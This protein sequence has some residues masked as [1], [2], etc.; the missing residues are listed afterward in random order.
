MKITKNQILKYLN[1]FHETE[2]RFPEYDPVITG[3]STDSREIKG[4]ELYIAIKGE[5]ND[6]NDYIDMVVENGAKLVLTSSETDLKQAIIVKDTVESLGN[7]ARGYIEEFDIA[8]LAVTG[9]SGKTTT[10]DMLYYIVSQA[11]PAIATRGN[12][13]NEIGLP[14][15]AFRLESSHRA[16]IFEMGMSSLGEIEYLCSIVKPHIG[17]ITNIGSCHIEHLKTREN[18]FKAKMEITTY[19]GEDNILIV[20]GDDEYLSTLDPAD[21]PYRIIK[22]GFSEKN[23]IMIS[24]YQIKDEMAVFTLSGLDIDSREFVIPA[25]GRHNA[26]NASLCI[27]AAFLMNIPYEKIAKG[28]LDFKPSQLRM[29]IKRKNGITLINDSYNANP[30]SMKAVISSIRDYVSKRR[31]A[32]LAD[33]LELGDISDISH[34]EVIKEA[35]MEFDIVIVIGENMKKASEFV[36]SSSGVQNLLVFDDN[37]MAI[38]KIKSIIK[39]GDIVLIKGSRGMKL[40]HVAQEL[41]MTI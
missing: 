40:D 3:V 16:A 37:D 17:I 11:M 20:N 33:M 9:S 34:R 30:E 28:L 18:I 15:T 19:F 1:E 24:N 41:Q 5:N 7:I 13:N 2:D 35:L 36:I 38:N 39:Y 25:V 10:K 31:I 27:A 23:D 12:F 4:E 22:C 8:K 32:V 14:L 6:G 21:N 29:D 26:V